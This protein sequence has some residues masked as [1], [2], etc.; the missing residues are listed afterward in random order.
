MERMTRKNPNGTYRLP[1][2]NTESFRMEWQQEMP[3]FF[4]TSV[5]KLGKYE[6][7]GTPLWDKKIAHVREYVSRASAA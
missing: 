7:I 3:V 2:T 6:D 5:D 1:A 4:G